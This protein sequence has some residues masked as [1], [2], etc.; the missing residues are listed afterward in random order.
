[1]WYKISGR[2]ETKYW[3]KNE[4]EVYPEEKTLMEHLYK[5]LPHLDPNLD[6]VK[7]FYL[8]GKIQNLLSSS[9]MSFQ[10]ILDKVK[11]GDLFKSYQQGRY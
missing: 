3:Y 8:K 1:M 9:G 6:S 5:L 2:K 7:F 10:E 11:N 4:G